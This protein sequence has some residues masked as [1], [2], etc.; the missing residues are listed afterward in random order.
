MKVL[1]SSGF[2]LFQFISMDLSALFYFNRVYLFHFIQVS[3]NNLILV[4]AALSFNFNYY[5]IH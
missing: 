5:G 2:L 4:K 3:G 1:I